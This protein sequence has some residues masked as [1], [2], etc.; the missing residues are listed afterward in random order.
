[1]SFERFT[2]WR[3]PFIYGAIKFASPP[4]EPG[5]FWIISRLRIETI[6]G[7]GIQN[8]GLALG[9]HLGR[10]LTNDFDAADQAVD[11]H[12]ILIEIGSLLPSDIRLGFSCRIEHVTQPDEVIVGHTTPRPCVQPHRGSS[13]SDRR[14]C[15]DRPCGRG[16]SKLA[17]DRR[18]PNQTHRPP[19]F[20]LH[21]QSTSLSGP[22]LSRRTDPK[23]ARR[24]MKCRREKSA[25]ARRSMAIAAGMN[26]DSSQSISQ[27]KNWTTG[28]LIPDSI[29]RQAPA[30]VE[31]T[32]R[33]PHAPPSTTAI[34]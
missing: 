6:S 13:G 17:L 23:N 25:T 19:G 9:R 24:R 16:F 28:S 8:L 2:R 30:F 31:A 29:L 22:K 3:P 7:H 12:A 26:C 33:C 15:A 11:Q 18:Q 20:K 21:Q 5:V 14:A 32:C 1:M 4:A 27:S 10:G 34:A